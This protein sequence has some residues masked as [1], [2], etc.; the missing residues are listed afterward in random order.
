MRVAIL[1][2]GGQVGTALARRYATLEGVTPVA[3]FRNAVAAARFDGVAGVEVRV[4][5]VSDLSAAIRL[6]GDCDAAINC[7]IATGLPHASRR[8]NAMLVEGVAAAARA[9]GRLRT[10][11]QLSSVGV[12]GRIYHPTT[13]SCFVR[14]RATSAYGRDKLNIERKARDAFAPGSVA[15]FVVRLGHVYGPYQINSRGFLA[16]ARDGAELPF[17][18]A[19]PS[20]TIH[21]DRLAL[22]LADACSGKIP[23][24]TYNGIDHPNRSWREVFDWHTG[25]AGIDPI[26]VLSDIQSESIRDQLLR[27]ERTS[28]ACKLVREVTQAFTSAPMAQLASSQVVRDLAYALLSVLPG[29]V[30]S[31]IKAGYSDWSVQRQ[32]ASLQSAPSSPIGP[33]YFCEA[34]PGPSLGEAASVEAR[35]NATELAREFAEWA[36]RAT[37]PEWFG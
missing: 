26:R 19:L 1:G 30:E 14:P 24:G 18:G 7:A 5:D 2:A 29:A 8:T 27:D 23:A 21:V 12:Y 11:I 16:M 22:M 4:G 3:L 25:T 15:V 10:F 31:R 32:I 36:R 9:E 34:V 17:D 20:N 13:G 28:S 33:L 37:V 6:V 35:L